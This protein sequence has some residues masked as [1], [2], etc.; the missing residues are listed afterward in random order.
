MLEVLS[1]VPTIMRKWHCVLNSVENEGVL[2]LTGILI[3]LE[4]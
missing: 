1:K 3:W 2:F 4:T